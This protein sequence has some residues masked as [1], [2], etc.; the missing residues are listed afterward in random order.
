MNELI[1]VCGLACHQCGAF[2]ATKEDDD[3]KR[4][5]VAELWSREHDANLK[6]Q[7]IHCEGCISVGGILFSHCTV[8]EIRRCG[9][10]KGVINCAYCEEYAC[11]M[12][13]EFFALVPESK[14]RLDGIRAGI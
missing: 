8:C 12:L 5:E 14:V 1:G 3:E 7:D 9:R 4:K 11:S 6:A 10:E 2:L 13:V